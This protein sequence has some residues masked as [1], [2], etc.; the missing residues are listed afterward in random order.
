M[1]IKDKDK[2]TCSNDLEY[3]SCPYDEEINDNHDQENC[4]CCPYCTYECAMDI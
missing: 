3:H 4:N 2:C 1:W